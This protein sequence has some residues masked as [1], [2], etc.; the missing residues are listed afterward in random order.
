MILYLYPDNS[1]LGCV[2]VNVLVVVPEYGASSG[3]LNHETPSSLLSCH[4]YVI[5]SPPGTEAVITKEPDPE[6]SNSRLD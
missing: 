4:W 5:L 2:R 6:E 3:T 1:E